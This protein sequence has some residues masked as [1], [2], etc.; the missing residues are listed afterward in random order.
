MTFSGLA[1]KGAWI[2]PSGITAWTKAAAR[3]AQMSGKVD[4]S[5][6]NAATNT[7][8][9]PIRDATKDSFPEI[10]D[11]F[12][13][14]YDGEEP[15]IGIQGDLVPAAQEMEYGTETQAPNPVARFTMADNRQ[16]AVSVF[17]QG[18]VG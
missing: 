8:I 3:Y 16:Q 13:V 4:D 17:Q 11:A 15:Y 14:F 10:S 12:E 5:A 6:K 2:N 7:I 18:L 9:Q 1:S